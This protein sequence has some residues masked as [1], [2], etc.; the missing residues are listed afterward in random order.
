MVALCSLLLLEFWYV[1]KVL[2]YANCSSKMRFSDVF[3]GV[4][5]QDFGRRSK[6]RFL[7]SC[8]IMQRNRVLL[9]GLEMERCCVIPW[10]PLDRPPVSGLEYI[11]VHCKLYIIY[12]FAPT[13]KFIY[14]FTEL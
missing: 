14:K 2:A 10:R 11:I 8:R 6:T 3:T 7:M 9:F 4:K 13:V 12:I 1:C 5:N